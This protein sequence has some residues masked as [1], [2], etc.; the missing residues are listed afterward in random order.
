[1]Y[2][3]GHAFFSV[4][5]YLHCMMCVAFEGHGPCCILLYC[6]QNMCY[7]AK[8]TTEHYTYRPATTGV[9][10]RV[11]INHIHTTDDD[12]CLRYFKNINYNISVK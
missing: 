9:N 8:V 10:I 1:M 4:C 7:T 12:L 11:A 3:N 5:I 2:I 6:P